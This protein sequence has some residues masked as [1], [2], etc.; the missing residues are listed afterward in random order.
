M[1]N[2]WANLL[3]RDTE[4]EGQ[5]WSRTWRLSNW[6][7]LQQLDLEI[8]SK[9][10]GETDGCFFPCFR[11]DTWRNHDGTGVGWDEEL[12]KEEAIQELDEE[13]Q[14]EVDQVARVELARLKSVCYVH[15]FDRWTIAELF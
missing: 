5:E 12:L 8:D 7:H 6:A 4:D 15:H 3:I 1:R 14:L 2:D 13:I 10:F 9:K 11:Q